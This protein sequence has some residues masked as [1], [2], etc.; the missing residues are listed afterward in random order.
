MD[1]LQLI[2]FSV[3]NGIFNE[4]LNIKRICFFHQ[5]L[6]CSVGQLTD[7]LFI[8]FHCYCVV[9]NFHTLFK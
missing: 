6:D 2:H 1:P 7:C 9:H 8:Y 4:L 3:R 5:L